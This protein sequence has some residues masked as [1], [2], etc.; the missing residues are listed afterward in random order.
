MTEQPDSQQSQQNNEENVST[1]ILECPLSYSLTDENNTP[2]AEGSGQARLDEEKLMVIPEFDIPFPIPY[3]DIVSITLGDYRLKLILSSGET[4]T[5]YN[6]GYKYED[7]SRDITRL[8]NQV[9]IKDLLMEEAYSGVSVKAQLTSLNP[10]TGLSTTMLCEARLYETGLVIIPE[11]QYP[12]RLPY[13]VIFGITKQDYAIELVTDTGERFVLSKM[14]DQF[15]LFV[16]TL[17]QVMTNLSLKLQE[18]IKD[19]LDKTSPINARKITQIMK[20]GKAVK[21]MDIQA[22]DPQIWLKLEDKIN[23][24]SIKEEYH[25]LKSLGRQDRICIGIKRGLMGDLTDEYIWLLV[26][27]YD[28]DPNKPGN[29]VAMTAFTEKDKG[30]ATYFFRITDREEYKGF[31]SIEQLNQKT[32]DIINMLNFSMLMVNFRREPIYLSE[33]Q[34]KNPRYL[35]YRFAI[36]NLHS[37]KTLRHLFIGRV[38]HSSPEQWKQDVMDLLTFNVSDQSKDKRWNKRR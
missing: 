6:L 10:V 7:F 37:L 11:D 5:L 34:L 27:I 16:K 29:A 20:D 32:D 4:L 19:L 21:R 15:D 24:H 17:S 9:L 35:K 26:P 31:K 30:G 13:G 3:Q 14:A 1:V 36:D 12:F 25:F 23:N 28:M 8:R 22:V 2:Q 38:I 33:K 18:S